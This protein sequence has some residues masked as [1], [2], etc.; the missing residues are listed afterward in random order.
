MESANLKITQTAREKRIKL[1]KL[2]YFSVAHMIV[3]NSISALHKVTLCRSDSMD[4]ILWIVV[5]ILWSGAHCGAKSELK[6]I[7]V[8]VSSEPIMVILFISAILICSFLLFYSE[9]TNE[10]YK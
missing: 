7:L 1:S 4:Q 6:S 10:Y 9:I 8:G 2:L 3:K 5:K